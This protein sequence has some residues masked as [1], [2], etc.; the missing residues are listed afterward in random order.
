MKRILLTAF[1]LALLLTGCAAAPQSPD[2]DFTTLGSARVESLLYDMLANPGDYLDQAVKVRGEYQSNH[3][4]LTGRD[5]HLVIIEGHTEC[6]NQGLE[7]M[8]A[9]DDPAYPAGGA[10]VEFTGVLRVYEELGSTYFYL[11]TEEVTVLED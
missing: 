6:C 8:L 7:F 4:D 2:I 11:R 1:L 9:G 10:I 3:S 5:Y